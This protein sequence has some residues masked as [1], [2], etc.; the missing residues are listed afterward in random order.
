MGVRL[1]QARIET[2]S[3][4]VSVRFSLTNV[5]TRFDKTD[6]DFCHCFLEEKNLIR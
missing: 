6:H 3:N 5:Y 4:T 1:K 2:N